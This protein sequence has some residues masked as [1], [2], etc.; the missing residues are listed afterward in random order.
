MTADKR[1]LNDRMIYIEHHDNINMQFKTDRPNYG[2]RDSIALK[3]KVTD[4]TGKPIAGNFSLAVTDDAQV[5][6]DT[7]NNENIVSRMLLTADLKGYIEEPGYYLSS[8]TAE[9]GR[10][11]DNLLLTQGWVGYDWDQVFNLPA[12][13]YQPETEFIVKGGVFNVFNKPVKGTHVLFFSKSPTI[14]MDTTTNKR[15]EFVFDHLP[16]VDTPLFV[17]KAVNKNGKSFNVGIAVNEIKPPE[18]TKSNAPLTGPWYV[19]SDPTLLNYTKNKAL[20]MQ[21]EYFPEGGQIL[22]EVKIT[23]KKIIK[24]SQNLNGPGNADLVLDEKDMEKSGKKNWLQLLQ[25]NIQGF[26]EANQLYKIETTAYSGNLPIDVVTR[27]Y[28]RLYLIHDKKVKLVIDGILLSEIYN[29]LD[30]VTL[31]N[32]L[33]SHNAEDIKGIEVNSSNIYAIN[34]ASRFGFKLNPKSVWGVNSDSLAFIEITT[35]SGHGPVIDNTPGMYLYK[36][37]AISQ[38]KQFYKPKYTVKDTA[39]HVPDL[40]ST[41]D[42]EPN[43]TTGA[44][45][46]ATVSFFTADK[47]STYTLIMEGTDMNGNLGYKQW[48]IDV[49]QSQD[50]SK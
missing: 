47:P 26:R 49:S 12:I 28:E 15:G 45:G 39:N 7:L 4:N 30:F 3:I 48:K 37:L 31:K 35:R 9:S 18:F 8:K 6:T 41:I 43:I 2:A 17:L 5:K 20:A 10:A 11:L 13:T 24:D 46:E 14:L 44:S 50:K 25:E 29:P 32:Y 27:N 23:A 38:P 36:P 1:A 42:W 22:K 34:Y 33:E 40:R 16:R 21:Q 19:N